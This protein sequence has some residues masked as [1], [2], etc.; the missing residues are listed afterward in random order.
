[1]ARATPPIE[2]DSG[3]SHVSPPDAAPRD[4]S[5]GLDLRHSHT[6]DKISSFLRMGEFRRRQFMELARL[7]VQF[8]AKLAPIL[9]DWDCM[10][11]PL[12]NAVDLDALCEAHDVDPH[13]FLGVV[14]AAAMKYRNDSS[15]IIA[16][17][18]FPQVI[19]KTIEHAMGKDGF[20]DCEALMKHAGFL[21]QPKG[22]Q[23]RVLN[24]AAFR[25]EVNTNIGEPLPT[26]EETIAELDELMS[27]GE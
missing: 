27:D 15:V 4:H 16:A 9:E 7:A 12:Q 8:D 6:S 19:Q 3:A 24:Y 5:P 14:G 21:P 17:L 18:S 13:H 11:P 25:A 26:F 20:K 22:S 2:P 10:K 1:V 23:V